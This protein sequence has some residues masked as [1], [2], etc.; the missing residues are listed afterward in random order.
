[1]IRHNNPVHAVLDAERRIFSS[2]DPLDEERN[3]ETTSSWAQQFTAAAA[4]AVPQM[5]SRISARMSS[6]ENSCWPGDD[7]GDHDVHL[8]QH[9][10][11]ERRATAADSPAC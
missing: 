8:S 3:L 11:A 1:M 4:D 2:E 5:M 9:A 10:R 7:P 6:N